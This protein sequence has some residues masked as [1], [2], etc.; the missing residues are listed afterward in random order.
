MA[1][2]FPSG[3]A[4]NGYVPQESLPNPFCSSGTFT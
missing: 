2:G 1:R 3:R 4:L